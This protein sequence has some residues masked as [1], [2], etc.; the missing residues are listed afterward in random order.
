MARPGQQSRPRAPASRCATRQGAVWRPASLLSSGGIHACCCCWCCWCWCWCW[1]CWLCWQGEFGL[2]N[3]QD[4]F[5]ATAFLVGLLLASPVFSE[6][7]KHYSAFRCVRACVPVTAERCRGGVCVR[8]PPSTQQDSQ[9]AAV[10]VTLPRCL[11]PPCSRHTHTRRLI[12]IGMGTWTLAGGVGLLDTLERRTAG[13][14]A[15]WPTHLHPALPALP[16]R[17]SGWLWVGAH[18]LGAHRLPH[19]GGRGRGLVRGAGSAIH[20]CGGGGG[21]R[22]EDT[23]SQGA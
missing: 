13:Q 15:P 5:L 8:H 22:G 1:C 21:G 6:S 18:L 23:A 11:P 9:K 12:G 14:V 10:A 4:G 19:A 16:G 2:S 7:C 3:L 17:C 20:R